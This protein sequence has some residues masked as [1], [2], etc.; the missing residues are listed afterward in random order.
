M[1]HKYILITWV[2][3][4]SSAYNYLS[5]FYNAKT[6]WN[7]IQETIFFVLKEGYHRHSQLHEPESLPPRVYSFFVIHFQETKFEMSENGCESIC[8]AERSQETVEHELMSQD[9]SASE[10]Q[11]S[12][13]YKCVEFTAY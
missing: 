5:L 10:T 7:L 3:I 13:W 1:G 4:F 8:I 6:T 11:Q 2:F 12:V 9:T